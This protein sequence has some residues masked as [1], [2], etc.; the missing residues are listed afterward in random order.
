MGVETKIGDGE[1]ENGLA[2]V[3]STKSYGGGLKVYAY[4]GDPLNNRGSYFTNDSN[5]ANMNIDGSVGGTPVQI[6][7]G[8]DNVYWTGSSIVGTKATFNDTTRF[9]DGAQSVK[10]DNPAVNDIIQFDKGSNLTV[11]SYNA[12]TIW[13][14]IDK[15]WTA[16]DSYEFYGYD[17]GTAATVGNVVLLEDYIVETNFDVWQKATIPLSDMGLTGGTIDALRMKL[18]SKTGKAP[19]F[20]L[21]VLRVE[22]TGGGIIFSSGPP[23]DKTW[24]VRGLSY[25]MARAYAGTLADASM[26]SIPYDG[27]LGLASLPTGITIRRVQG[28][29][30]QLQT[31][32]T[33][34]IDIIASFSHNTMINGSDGT[35]TW[36]RIDVQFP[37]PVKLVGSARDRFEIVIND[38]LSS[39]LFFK[40]NMTIGEH[41]EII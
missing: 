22:E 34:L 35:N 38:D 1:S 37:Y 15:D 13:I 5:G 36:L 30:V 19:K 33:D 32:Y 20:Y 29:V 6:H 41:K 9:K 11:A 16:G 28:E 23:S 12:I 27:F 7:N 24:E 40:A 25:T 8:I 3:R 18:I 4:D 14:N 26:P 31:N 39:L 21:D 10:W 2:G 17:T